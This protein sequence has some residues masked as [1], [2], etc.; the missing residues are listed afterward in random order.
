MVTRVTSIDR[1]GD[2]TAAASERDL[3]NSA[4]STATISASNTVQPVA[5][6]DRTFSF[7]SP[8]WDAQ[9]EDGATAYQDEI[10]ALAQKSSRYRYKRTSS[11]E[12]NKQDEAFSDPAERQGSVHPAQ[13]FASP[14]SS[15]NQSPQ[16]SLIPASAG[17][18]KDSVSVAEQNNLPP[19]QNQYQQNKAKIV[20]SKRKIQNTK[21]P[22]MVRDLFA[23]N[24]GPPISIHPSIG[25]RITPEDS[26]DEVP[27]RIRVTR[28]VVKDHSKRLRNEPKSPCKSLN[29]RRLMSAEFKFK[30]QVK[31]EKGSIASPASSMNQSPARSPS[32]TAQPFSLSSNMPVSKQIEDCDILQT[33]QNWEKEKGTPFERSLPFS[34]SP[35]NPCTLRENQQAHQLTRM[36]SPGATPSGHGQS[37]FI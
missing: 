33:W 24:D 8:S 28:T 35:A 27:T 31:M 21:V 32:Q 37:P 17:P 14:A 34:A 12:L 2:W 30:D 4:S 18:Q 7:A 15:R 36:R 1:W 16:H 20:P 23:H 25:A 3:I 5:R 9:L 10:Q 13:S 6:T 19:S 29:I 26:D 11:L 22:A